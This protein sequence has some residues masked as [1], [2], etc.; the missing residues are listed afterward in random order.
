MHHHDDDPH[1]HGNAVDL[2]TP[3]AWPI[4]TAFGL[5]LA[6]TGLVTDYIV[7]LVGLLCGALGAIGWFTD[8]FPHPKHEPVP[9]VPED[10]RAKP[11]S[12]EGRV[13][14]HLHPGEEG[15][16]EH[17]VAGAVHPYSAGIVAG[18]AGAVA[19]AVIACLWGL[20][21]EKSIW[22]PVNLLA[23]GALS[24]L[25]TA[26]VETL[27]QFSLLGLVVGSVI[28][29]TTAALVGLLYTVLLPMLPAKREWIW[30]YIVTPLL[31]TALIF[32]TLRFINPVLN[33]RINWLAFV[34]SQLAFGAVCGFLVYRSTRVDVQQG[35][36]ISA[37]LGVEAQH[38]NKE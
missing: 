5:T 29:F 6:F 24:E 14:S 25:A 28:H 23:A 34:V 35:L 3:T 32:F 17:V 33:E 7:S 31:W 15:H 8:V 12:R 36:P 9:F 30:G 11:V 16:R 27:K 38:P 21:F 2:P 19:M 37:R 10:K 20:I 26:P 22:Y 13:V 1:S 4:I 18:L